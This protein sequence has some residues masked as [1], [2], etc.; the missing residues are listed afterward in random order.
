MRDFMRR[1]P[2][3]FAP[4]SA[5][6]TWIRVYSYAAELEKQ[7]R[8]AGFMKLGDRQ[9]IALAQVTRD[10]LLEAI[11]AGLLRAEG[12]DVIVEGYDLDG[13]AKVNTARE[14]GKFG[15]LGAE[16]GKLGGR[17]RKKP[18]AGGN[19]K[20]PAGDVSKPPAG[21]SDIPPSASAS[22]SAAA[23]ASAFT[24]SEAEAEEITHRGGETDGDRSLV[25]S[26][27]AKLVGLWKQKYP[28]PYVSTSAD[29][30]S[31]ELVIT[32]FKA[33]GALDE[34]ESLPVWFNRFL[35]DARGAYTRRRHR[36]SQFVDDLSQFRI[37]DAE[38]MHANG[39]LTPEEELAALERERAA[40]QGG[41][42]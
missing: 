35:H 1:P 29:R 22:A 42:A 37:S 36:I 4:G 33:D 39:L 20:P 15:H 28:G 31:L 16:A 10:E 21:V 19:S 23:S 38:A 41:A 34:I 40:A 12:D 13:E 11:R 26:M 3:A 9:L 17:P 18:P 24:G 27:L 6:G 32:S 7:G 5:L 14:N 2:A 25:D 8:L 30:E